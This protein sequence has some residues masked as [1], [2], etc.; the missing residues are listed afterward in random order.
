MARRKDDTKHCDPEPPGE[1][2]R[3][4]EIAPIEQSAR[5]STWCPCSGD[6]AWPGRRSDQLMAVISTLT[7]SATMTVLKVKAMRLCR[8]TTLL[9]DEVTR[10]TSED[11]KVVDTCTER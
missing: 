11:E 7:S 1:E 9:I 3:L 2:G 4:D 8:E 10:A 5:T 6:G